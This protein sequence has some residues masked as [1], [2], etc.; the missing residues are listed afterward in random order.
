MGTGSIIRPGDVQRMS[1]G[2]G[3]THSEFNASPDR[4]RALP[5]DLDRARRRAAA[6]ELRAEGV[7]RRRASAARLR[8]VASPDGRDGSLTIQQD[9]ALH[10]GTAAHG[11]GA[12]HAI[13]PGRH[14]WVHVAR[15]HVE[16]GGEQ[17]DAGD[18]VAV[19]EARGLEM[20][21]AGIRR[22]SCCSTSRDR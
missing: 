12:A 1:A 15:G 17:L 3:V 5:A 22:K 14:A 2:T 4:A 19:S 9:V 10:I 21:A 20:S 6:A 7:H 16:L 11:R 18:A 13:A 8:L